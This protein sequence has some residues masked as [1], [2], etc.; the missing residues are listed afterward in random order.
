MVIY[1]IYNTKGGNIF[2]GQEQLHHFTN[3]SWEISLCDAWKIKLCKQ[4]AQIVFVDLWPRPLFL[5][6]LDLVNVDNECDASWWSRHLV[7]VLQDQPDSII[8]TV[9]AFIIMNTS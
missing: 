1:I 4:I 5:G 3:L 8:K 9:V 2:Y 6:P 7:Y